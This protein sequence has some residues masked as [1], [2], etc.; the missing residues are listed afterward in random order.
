MNMLKVK[1]S[2]T[3]L[4]GMMTI[5]AFS[6][7]AQAETRFAVQDSTG[8]TD[9]MVV[10]DSGYVGVGTS[11]PG[12]PFQIVGGATSAETTFEV[13]NIGGGTYNKYTT[14]TVRFMRNV[15]PTVN[16][17]NLASGDRIG[18]F[19]FGSYYG[20]LAKI[21]AA[22][23]VAADGNFSSTSYPG[24][25]SLL[26]ASPTDTN[27]IERLT[28]ISTGN[29]GVGTLKPKQK[30]EINGGVRLNTATTK[31]VCDVLSRGTLWYTNGASLTA[32]ALEICFKEATDTYA[33]VKIH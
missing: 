20:S 33:W 24:S 28:V 10:T 7:I 8:T 14:P 22:I 17:G 27:P 2:I 32:D 6:G 26:T 18:Y 19:S 3:L 12:F 15:D 29:V 31:P 13:K 5:T 30:L 16:G 4:V 23:A 21:A 25:I 9:K 1:K 11:V